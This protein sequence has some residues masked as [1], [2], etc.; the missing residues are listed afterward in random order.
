MNPHIYLFFSILLVTGSQFLFKRGVEE[1]GK[2]ENKEAGESKGLMG[3]VKML[4]QPHIFIGFGLNG[5]AAV[6][7][8]LALSHLELSYVFPFLS[9]NYI[10]IPVGAHFLFD[11]KLSLYKT[12]GI[13]IICGGIFL[14][15]MS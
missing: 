8:L 5:L 13:A 6:C 11:E 10:L 9:L 12:I 2:Q 7:W 4:F 1:L 15:A 3:Y 14:I